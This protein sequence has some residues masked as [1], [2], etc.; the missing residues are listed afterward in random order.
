MAELQ[1]CM[2]LRS[3][4]YLG[5]TLGVVPS[6]GLDQCVMTCTH[7]YDVIQKSLPAL[8]IPSALAVHPPPFL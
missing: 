5:L 3:M 6:G 8:K 1:G 4:V 7:H 2:C